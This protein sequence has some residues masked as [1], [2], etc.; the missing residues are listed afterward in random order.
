[1][2]RIYGPFSVIFKAAPIGYGGGNVAR[3]KRS[4]S[5]QEIVYS[6]LIKRARKQADL[7]RRQRRCKKNPDGTIRRKA[8]IPRELWVAE[9]RRTGNKNYWL[10]EG[11]KALKQHDLLFQS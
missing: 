7:E 6:R 1:M 8:V 2:A 11:E 5:Q 9:Q 4:P 10:D 3:R